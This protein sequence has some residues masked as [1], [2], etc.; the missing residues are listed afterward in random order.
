MNENLTPDDF[1]SALLAQDACWGS[2][3]FLERR[4]QL[5]ERVERAAKN[6]KRARK[7]LVF[8]CAGGGVVFAI[9]CI[10]ATRQASAVVGWPDWVKTALAL[11]FFLTPVTLVLLLGVYL[12]RYRLELVKARREA[13][14]RALEELPK[15]LEQL[16]RELDEL[17][18]QIKPQK[19]QAP[20]GGSAFTL[21]EMLVV[22]AILVILGSMVF[23]ALSHGKSRARTTECKN[24]LS[25]M[26][27]ALSISKVL[28]LTARALE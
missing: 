11:V 21:T 13:R 6:E 1:A 25:Q 17:K 14:Q 7:L 26:G 16:R 5:I 8:A 28:G 15:R 2:P 18:A 12:F 4:R 3:E 23:S 22:I 19:G 20:E 10:L 24:H 9:L 27:K